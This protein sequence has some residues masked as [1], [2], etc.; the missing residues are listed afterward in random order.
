ML[1]TTGP[2]GSRS[3]AR[4]QG[5]LSGELSPQEREDLLD[6]RVGPR[7]VV[8]QIERVR[9][10]CVLDQSYRQLVRAGGGDE[11]ELRGRAGD[12]GGA[13]EVEQV[14]VE[15]RGARE[16]LAR[17][18]PE[19]GGLRMMSGFILASVGRSRVPSGRNTR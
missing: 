13:V 17:D 16:R 15:Q 11:V 10:L 3:L 4:R 14:R 6:H 19:R 1:K 7:R 12:R 9:R 5:E 2:S 8:L 18:Q